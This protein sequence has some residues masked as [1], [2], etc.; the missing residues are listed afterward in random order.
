VTQRSDH[1]SVSVE[2][3]V[4]TPAFAIMIALVL[5]VGRTQSSRADLEAAAHAAARTVTLSRDPNT[6]AEI[7][8]DEAI[9]RL[10]VGSPSCRTLGWDLAISGQDATVTLTCTVDL[11]EA[12]LLPVPGSIQVSATST[13]PLDRFAEG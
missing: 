11:S 2:L 8:H 7:A 10:D 12:A 13:E 9:E 4:L 5:L 3:A 6:A 1:G